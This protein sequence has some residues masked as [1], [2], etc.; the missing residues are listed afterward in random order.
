MYYINGR[1]NR[2]CCCMIMGVYEKWRPACS[3]CSGQECFAAAD[4]KG[5]F[6]V[7]R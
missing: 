4:V 3:G 2:M 5:R 1:D 6:I 7:L